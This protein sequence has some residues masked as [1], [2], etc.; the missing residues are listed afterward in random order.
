MKKATYIHARSPVKY[1]HLTQSHN[2]CF[3]FLH[4]N[5]VDTGV[6][7]LEREGCLVNVQFSK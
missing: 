4:A 2:D 1:I 5:E 7:Q 6:L 3:L